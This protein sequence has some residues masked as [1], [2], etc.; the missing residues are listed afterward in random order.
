[1]DEPLKSVM[2]G[3]CDARP[4]V[5]FPAVGHRH[6]TATNLYCLM[7]EAHACEQLAWGR[8]LTGERPGV[9]QQPFESRVQRPNHYHHQAMILGYVE[10]ME[11]MVG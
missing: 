3:Q 4:T 6:L 1:M 2:H 5:T 7:T 10:F 8:Y 9:K 11:D